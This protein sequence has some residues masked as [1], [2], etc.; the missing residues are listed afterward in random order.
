MKKGYGL[1]VVNVLYALG[2]FNFLVT[3]A[4]IM[5]TGYILREE[6]GIGTL[7]VLI[8]SGLVGV[9]IGFLVYAS[10]YASAK[11][12]ENIATIAWH[13]EQLTKQTIKE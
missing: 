4:S 2:I 13:T 6:F 8:A 3:V 1:W 11:L 12:F 9:V 5:Y 10:F 7:Y